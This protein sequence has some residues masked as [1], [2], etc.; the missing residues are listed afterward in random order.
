[1]SLQNDINRS[2]HHYQVITKKLPEVIYMLNETFDKLRRELKYGDFNLDMEK[3]KPKFKDIAIEI[4]A[5]SKWMPKSGFY[6]GGEKKPY[7]GKEVLIYN[8]SNFK[9]N[10]DSKTIIKTDKNS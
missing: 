4:E 3:E 1:M 5:D 6:I 2:I 9:I 10:H 8:L 7:F